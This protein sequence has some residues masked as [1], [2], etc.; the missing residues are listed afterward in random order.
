MPASRMKPGQHD[1]HADAARV[2]LRAQRPARSRADRTSWRCTASCRARC[3]ARQRGDEQQVSAPA[4]DHRRQQRVCQHDRG[5]QVDAQRAVDLLL[6]EGL[7]A[8]RGRQRGVGDQDVHLARL[9]SQAVD[10]GGL[11]R[12]RR[13]ARAHPSSR[14]QRLQHLDAPPGQDQLRA[15]GVQ[16]AGD[17]LAETAGGAVSRTRSRAGD[18][19]ATELASA[20]SMQVIALFGPTGVG[21]TAV[22]LAL[23]RRLRQ[24]GEDPVAVSA[25]ALQVYAGLETLTGVASAREQAAAGASAGLVRAAARD[26]QRRAVREAGARGDRRA[27]G[28]RAAGR[29]W[30]A[31]P[32]CICARR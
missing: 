16:R 20:T 27:A 30:W 8:A 7:Q 6:G 3:L 14:G 28:G 29:S 31:A 11:A 9:A 2:E 18:A 17:R 32:G 23:A 26:V 19:A 15:A 1:G 4:R 13:P 5:A 12:G 21:K 22:A 25:D 24:R 10:L